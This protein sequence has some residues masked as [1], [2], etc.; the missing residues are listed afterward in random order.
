MTSSMDLPELRQLLERVTVLVSDM[1]RHVDLGEECKRLGL[2]T[3]PDEGTKNQRVKA[4]LANLPDIGLPMVAEK[5]LASRLPLGAAT[6]NAIQDILW[7]GQGNLEMPKRTRR[8]I[9]RDLDLADLVRSVDRFTA[10]LDRL[11]IL[12]DDPFSLLTGG[13][14]SLRARIERHVYRNP[15]DW[16]TEE[17]L[18]QLGAFEAGDARFARFLEGLASAEVILDEAAQR[19]IVEAVNPHLHSVG[20][21]L[22]ETGEDEGYPVFSIVSTQA[23]RN[24]QAK[25]IIFASQVKPDIRFRDA[26]NNDIEIVEN[27]DK[28]LVYEKSIGGDGLRWRDLQ[29]WWMNRERLTDDADAKKSLYKRL[30]SCLPPNSPPQR[31]LYELYHEIHGSMVP[32]LPALLPEVWL[33][34]DP[35]TVRDRGT[36]ALLRFRM[37]FLLLLRHG[38]R[39]V[40][41]VDGAHHFTGPD[42]RPNGARYAENIRGDRDLKLSGY[43]VFRFGATELQDREH[44]RVMLQQFFADLFGRFEITSAG[45]KPLRH[46][47]PGP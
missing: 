38:Q 23:A 21:E 36:Q 11:W 4:S 19:S 26:V 16:S 47:S 30:I 44:A 41:E 37:D 3:P 39:V 1:N 29:A 46:S 13:T 12:D 22:R 10:L 15:D 35:K 33:H 8:E 17:L 32:D 34:W 25:N 28:V 7:A 18:E 2:P 24:R 20:L 31:N 43:E 14:T 5:I 45:T 40:I 9:A 42:G 6:R 27:A